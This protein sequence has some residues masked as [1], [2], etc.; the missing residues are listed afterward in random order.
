MNKC[1]LCAKLCVKHREFFYVPSI[2]L[3][4]ENVCFNKIVF[5]LLKLITLLI[6]LI[7]G[8]VILCTIDFI[9]EETRMTY[10]MLFLPVQ[11][12]TMT[13]REL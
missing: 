6:N 9:R 8:C 1:W 11:R 13:A 7:A 3:G 2:V 5:A 10:I 4:M 12:I